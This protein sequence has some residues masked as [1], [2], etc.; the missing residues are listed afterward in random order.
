MAIIRTMSFNLRTDTP[1]DGANNFLLRTPRILAFLRKEM[2]DLIGFQEATDLIRAWLREHLCHDYTLIGCGRNVDYRG[3]SA[4]LAFRTDRFEMIEARTL[5]LSPTPSEPGTT[6][7]GDQSECPRVVTAVKLKHC[8][9]KTPF[10]FINTHF[11]H[12]GEE[13]RQKEAAQLLDLIG[14]GEEPFILTGDFNALPDSPEIRAFTDYPRC[15][16]ADTTAALGGT[17]HAYGTLAEKCKID[18]IF[19]NAAY[20]PEKT[21]CVEDEGENG[22]YL[23]DH[24][25]VTAEI[26]IP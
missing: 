25:P 1:H 12:R 22:I 5:W 18:Y 2:P 19:T 15:R 23:S 26:I 21:R 11:D 7:G 6:Y 14:E 20:L 24:H 17:F 13:A 8:A 10:W 4:V 9:A 16:I 3:E